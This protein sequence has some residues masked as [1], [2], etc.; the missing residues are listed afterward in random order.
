VAAR[1]AGR[2]YQG[3]GRLEGDPVAWE[4]VPSE[5]AS[6]PGNRAIDIKNLEMAIKS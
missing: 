1:Q 5:S 3:V 6:G 2:T 4:V